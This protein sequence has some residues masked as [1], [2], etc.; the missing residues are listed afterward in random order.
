MS[1]DPNFGQQQCCVQEICCW[2]DEER[3][4]QL[5]KL[6]V[7]AGMPEHHAKVAATYMIDHF[8]LTAKGL[9]SPLI[10]YITKAA[11]AYPE[12]PG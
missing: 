6:L 2:T 10:R 1:A 11:R 12:Y 7:A 5:T 9:L 4:E 8:D 3:I